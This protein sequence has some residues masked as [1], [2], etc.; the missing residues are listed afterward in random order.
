MK[1]FLHLE[2]MLN[3]PRDLILEI[4]NNLASRGIINW[5]RAV[6][7]EGKLLLKPSLETLS[8]GEEHE[9]LDFLE[10]LG[11]KYPGKIVGEFEVWWPM[12]V[13]S[14]PQWWELG[15]DGKVYVT[16]SDI[17]RGEKKQY[18]ENTI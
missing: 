6:H 7:E 11:Q 1:V 16:E 8:P 14:G 4:G 2:G 5:F 10:E 13:D 17:I 9:F 15:E 12:A 3:V 18:K